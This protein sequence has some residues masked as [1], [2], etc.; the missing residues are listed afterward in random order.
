M[1]TK[2]TPYLLQPN[3]QQG[4]SLIE[5]L[6]A[7]ILS[8]IVLMA[9]TSSYFTARTLNKTASGRL[10]V[11]QDLR[12]AS[13]LI[14]RD[15]RMAGSFGCF[16]MA[17][18]QAGAVKADGK[19]SNAGI[20]LKTAKQN[21]LVPIKELNKNQI[22]IGNFNAQ[23]SFLL[24]Q[25]GVDSGNIDALGEDIRNGAPAVFS[26]CSAIARPENTLKT[27]EEI[28][29]LLGV[30]SSSDGDIATMR[31]TVNAYAVG[32]SGQQSGLFRFQLGNNGQW[33]APQL[34][35]PNVDSWTVSYLYVTPGSC[36]NGDAAAKETFDDAQ[37]L[38]TGNEAATPVMVRIRLNNGTAIKSGE[39]E[40]YV[41]NIDANVRG[42]NL[43]AD[44][45]L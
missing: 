28:R 6:V 19:S 22:N 33:S 7:S 3:C 31:Y 45:S 41:Y 37:A 2:N 11:Q 21:T 32:K 12:N 44:R 38:I 4:F 5:F 17:A 29:T 16:N 36:P 30:D 23:S 25:Y 15:A 27:K 35:I 8:M 24:F 40:I 39:N 13:N 42:G 9:V 1:K 10:I 34:L 26:T 20:Q 14:A 18:A 43:C